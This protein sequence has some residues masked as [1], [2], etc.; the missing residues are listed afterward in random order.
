[1]QGEEKCQ[2]YIMALE[3]YAQQRDLSLAHVF[4]WPTHTHGHAYYQ[5]I[6]REGAV[7]CGNVKI[8]HSGYCKDSVDQDDWGRGA[9]MWLY[10]EYILDRIADEPEDVRET[11]SRMALMCFAFIW[12]NRTQIYEIKPSSPASVGTY[13]SLP[14]WYLLSI[15]LR[16]LVLDR[17]S[18]LAA[19]ELLWRLR[20]YTL[21]SDKLSWGSLDSPHCDLGQIS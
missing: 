17:L 2:S 8:S 4:H 9:E 5:Q 6:S 3:D 21:E 20:A 12:H 7:K 15:L 14:L 18:L 13:H 16:A 19:G 10:S 1:M 11:E